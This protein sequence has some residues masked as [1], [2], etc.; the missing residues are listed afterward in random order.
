VEADAVAQRVAS[1]WS[2]TKVYTSPMKRCIHT[3]GAIARACKVEA[4]ILPDLNDINYG[5]WQW[6]SYD[7][8][9]QA[10]PQLFALWFAKPHLMRFPAGESFQELV[11]EVQTCCVLLSRLM[12]VPRLFSLAMTASI[13]PSCSSFSINL[14]QRIGD[15]LSTPVASTN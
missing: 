7:E 10:E 5:E 9:R 1:A 14:C 11:P 6:K 8:V 15:L 4:E 2:P 3:G 13:A 12:Q